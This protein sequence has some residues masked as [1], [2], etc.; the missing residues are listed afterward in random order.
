MEVRERE[1][2]GGGGG[3]TSTRLLSS[4]KRRVFLS[5]C[6]EVSQEQA[7]KLGGGTRGRGG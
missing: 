7:S 4:S 3:V 1:G 2:Q 6:Q 5:Y